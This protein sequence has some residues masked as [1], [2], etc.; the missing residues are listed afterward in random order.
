MTCETGPDS[1][2]LWGGQQHRFWQL[3]KRKGHLEGQAQRDAVARGAVACLV[4][5]DNSF[6]AFIFAFVVQFDSAAR[7][8]RN[9]EALADTHNVGAQ[10][11]TPSAPL[12][13]LV[14]QLGAAQ[15]V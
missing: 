10:L 2:R 3:H 7:E 15:M 11:K 1:I 14:P 9:F 13:L 12:G 8:D 4:S 5:E 6:F